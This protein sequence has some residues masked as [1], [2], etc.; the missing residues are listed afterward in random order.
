MSGLLPLAVVC[1]VTSRC[2]AIEASG[3]IHASQNLAKSGTEG[4]DVCACTVILHR[5]SVLGRWIVLHFTLVILSIAHLLKFFVALFDCPGP[6]ALLI[7]DLAV[8]SLSKVSGAHFC[9]GRVFVSGLL[10]L[11]VVCRVTSRCDAIEASGWIH[12]SQNLAK[13]G[14]EGTDVCAC[15]VILHRFSVLGRWIVLHFTLVILSIAHL[16]KFFVE[17]GHVVTCLAQR[18]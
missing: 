17:Y 15:T 8:H 4:T 16:L 13:S 10:P 9:G 6:I 7:F 2:D 3:W 14:T 11:A 1:R 18:S 5:F 12:A